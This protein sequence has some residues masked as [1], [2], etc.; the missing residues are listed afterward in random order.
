VALDE[1]GDALRPA[2]IWMDVRAHAEAD[3]VLA[4]GDPALALDGAGAGFGGM[5]DP[6]GALA[7]AE[8]SADL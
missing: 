4:T 8:R 6:Q 1:N 5:D 3:A 2:L 7:Q